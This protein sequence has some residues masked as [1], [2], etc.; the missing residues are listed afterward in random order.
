[1]TDAA[2]FFSATYAQARRKFLEVAAPHTT[3]SHANPTKGPEG[4]ALATDT[5][6]LGPATASR[7]LI[8]M[9]ATHGVEGFCGSGIQSGWL[10][11]GRLKSLPS[12]TAVLLIHAINPHG[13]AWVRR[14]NEDNVDLNRNFVDHSAPYPANPGYYEL[15]DAIC[16]ATWDDAT[17]AAAD[18][19]MAAYS[20]KHGLMALQA[21]VANGQYGD[22]HGV[23]YGG[24]APTWSNRTLR[25]ILA[26]FATTAKKVAFIDLHTGLGP[27]G[28]VEIISNHAS[29]QSGNKR[30]KAWYGPEATCID[31]GTSTS[32]AVTGDTNIGVEAALPQ[33]EVT[34]ITLEYGTRPVPEML[35]AVRADNWLHTHG[36]LDSIKGRCIKAQIRDAFYPQSDQ[37][38]DLV[39]ARAVQVLELTFRGLAG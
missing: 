18:T 28:Y 27:F 8:A 22:K 31:D 36:D 2:S 24:L 38:M 20:E 26:P 5:L 11:S 13:F 6:L 21:A 14:V 1:M 16:P 23:F 35:L 33:S 30:V 32:T 3:V 25:T 19:Q 12:D 7:L 29:G 4:E 10:Q 39:F 9:S 17:I 34:G 37:W 15:R